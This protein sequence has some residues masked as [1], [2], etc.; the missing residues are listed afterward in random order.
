MLAGLYDARSMLAFWLSISITN[1]S[2]V[3]AKDEPEVGRVMAESS[4]I[5]PGLPH[6]GWA[7]TVF[8]TQQGMRKYCCI[9]IPG[10]QGVGFDPTWV[11]DLPHDGAVRSFGQESL[12]QP[13]HK[14]GVISTKKLAIA[15]RLR[16][17]MPSSFHR[18]A[19]TTAVLMDSIR[20]EDNIQAK[21]TRCFRRHRGLIERAPCLWLA[22]DE[23][24]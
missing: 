11:K 5:E 8:F 18:E 6:R 1:F 3:P 12:R 17:C 23:R 13:G 21:T 2:P 10:L 4:K 14:T 22:G 15:S 16:C 7:R 24:I 9:L 19:M 20:F